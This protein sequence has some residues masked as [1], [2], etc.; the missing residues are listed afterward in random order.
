M[1]AMCEYRVS[2]RRQTDVAEFGGQVRKIRHFHAGQ[3]IDP[4]RIIPAGDNSVS[5]TANLAGDPAKVGHKALP[6]R[7]YV[8]QIGPAIVTLQAGNQEWLSVFD[9]CRFHINQYRWE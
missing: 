2:L 5:E 4:G 7:G 1:A 9:A 6:L 8:L 3:V